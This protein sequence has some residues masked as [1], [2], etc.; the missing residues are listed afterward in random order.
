MKNIIAFFILTT[1]LASCLGSKQATTATS[2]NTSNTA[3]TKNN[4]NTK[5]T[6]R[7]TS[8]ER[9][10]INHRI[11]EDGDSIKVFL[12][13]DIPRLREVDGRS[14]FNDEFVLNYGLLRDYLSKEFLEARR[15]QLSPQDI[16]KK[17]GL[18]YVHFNI[19]KQAFPRGV[20][21]I[22]FQDTSTG[23]KAIHDIPV[24]FAVT[25]IRDQFS[26][27]KEQGRIPHFGRYLLSGDKIQ[28]KD[29][30]NSPK[31]FIVRYYKSHFDPATPPMAA[32]IDRDGLRVLQSDSVFIIRSNQVLSFDSPGLYLLN[33]DTTNYYGLSFYVDKGR[34]PKLSKIADVI[35]PLIYIT[36]EEELQT[37]KTTRDSIGIKETKLEMD[38][39]WLKTTSGN[40]KA[41]QQTIR[42]YYQRVRMANK[43]F[44]TY[45]PGWK[46]D[47]GMIFI[48]YG[49]P[50]RIRRNDASEYWFYTQNTSF[51]EIKFTFQRK[52]NQFVDNSFRLARYPQYEQVWYPIIE[53]WRE[54][55]VQ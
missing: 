10:L 51:S 3:S 8:N 53:Q 15:L 29:L 7:T 5:T 11:L 21:I 4:K 24:P 45:K 44:T 30:K 36:T 16:N 33:N 46:T 13:L 40:A 55:K 38:K 18:Y 37:L 39:F 42:E 41:A 31:E 25:N 52:P 6:P 50:N 26:A 17:D 1:L 28:I 2:S 34:Y 27:F 47:M 14:S 9:I 20:V 43:F 49:S 35:E 32:N 19:K 54:G 48:I 12:E 23:Q 22:D